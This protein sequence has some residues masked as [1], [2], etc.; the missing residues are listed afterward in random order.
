MIATAG[1]LKLQLDKCSYHVSCCLSMFFPKLFFIFFM[2][3]TAHTSEFA[4][5]N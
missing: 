4:A 1:A 2:S 3:L 5:A